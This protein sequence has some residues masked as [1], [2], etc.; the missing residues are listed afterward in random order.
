MPLTHL[1]GLYWW[2]DWQPAPKDEFTALLMSEL[3]KPKW[4]IDGNMKH[5]IPLRLQYCDT[6][7]YMDFSSVSCICGVVKR[8]I[9]NYGKSRADMG[10]YCPERFNRADFDFMKTVWRF[11]KNNRQD[12]Y[13]YLDN[14]ENVIV[15]KNRKQVKAFLQKL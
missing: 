9:Q 4:I 7:L 8:V 14:V 13:E 1:D 3:E 2:D 15:L 10:G 5:S 6:V 12:F 11:N